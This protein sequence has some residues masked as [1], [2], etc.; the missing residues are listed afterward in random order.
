MLRVPRRCPQGKGWHL[1][2]ES[3]STMQCMEANNDTHC[4]SR[5][6]PCSHLGRYLYCECFLIKELFF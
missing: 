6:R 2:L 1:F 3:L 4:A 5:H